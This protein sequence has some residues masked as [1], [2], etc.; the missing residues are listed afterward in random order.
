[1]IIKTSYTLTQ[2]YAGYL[3]KCILHWG[4]FFL[5]AYKVKRRPI[6]SW[7]PIGSFPSGDFF[8]VCVRSRIQINAGCQIVIGKMQFC[9]NDFFNGMLFRSSSEYSC[10]Q[11]KKK[12]T[13]QLVGISRH[14]AKYNK[15]QIF[16]LNI[17]IQF[18]T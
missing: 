14:S 4:F 10:S 9:S 15:Q 5:H 13:L 12:K 18:I 3:T 17:S 11:Q 7:F 2:C 6:Y 1:M 8:C 16:N